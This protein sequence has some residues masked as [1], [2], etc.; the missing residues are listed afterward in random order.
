L[1]TKEPRPH[2]AMPYPWARAADAPNMIPTAVP[3]IASFLI[4]FLLG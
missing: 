3:K 1:N 2:P 4:R